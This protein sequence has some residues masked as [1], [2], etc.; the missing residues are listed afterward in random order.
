MELAEVV[1][2]AKEQYLR[3]NKTVRLLMRNLDLSQSK[4]A[5]VLGVSRQAV[6]QKVVGTSRFEPWELDGVA[7]A[8]GVPRE[9]VDMEPDEALRWALDHNLITS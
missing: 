4:V 2:R 6:H 7:A 3:R 5:E 9:V 8:M 1:A